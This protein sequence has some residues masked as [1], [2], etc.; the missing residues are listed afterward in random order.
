MT[1][2]KYHRILRIVI[3]I[4]LLMLLINITYFKL[5]NCNKC[6]FEI[7]GTNYRTNEFMKLYFNKC[8]IE[9]KNQL[10]SFNNFSSFP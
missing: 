7:N 1:L 4:L 8:L 2:Q 10:S 9:E 6:N 3:A 5:E